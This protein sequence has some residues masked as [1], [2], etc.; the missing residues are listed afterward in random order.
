[1]R[2]NPVVLKPGKRFRLSETAK[3]VA[4]KWIPP[5]VGTQQGF[6][7]GAIV[8]EVAAAST[9]NEELGQEAIRFL[10]KHHTAGP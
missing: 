6:H 5:R 2:K 8:R 3:G 1:M 4:Q 9:R 7:L 10:E